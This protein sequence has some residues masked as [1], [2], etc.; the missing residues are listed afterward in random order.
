MEMM[1]MGA[2][3]ASRRSERVEWSVP[4][5]GETW[6]GES[7]GKEMVTVRRYVVQC[8]SPGSFA[9][10]RSGGSHVAINGSNTMHKSQSKFGGSLL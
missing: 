5:C 3:V 1:M 9:S 2:D 8:Q 4:A 7:A 10:V 6:E